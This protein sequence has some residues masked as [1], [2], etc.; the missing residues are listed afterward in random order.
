MY[1]C[2]FVLKPRPVPTHLENKMHSKDLDTSFISLQTQYMLTI[3]NFLAL[4]SI[5]LKPTLVVKT[6][7]ES[8][9]LIQEL[10]H[11]SQGHHFSYFISSWC[12]KGML[13]KF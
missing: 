1:K 6:K 12:K 13:Y 9:G 5:L 8:V 10:L 7:M 3:L 2:V 11:Y 4:N